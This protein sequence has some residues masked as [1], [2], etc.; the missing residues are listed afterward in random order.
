MQPRRSGHGGGAR[1]QPLYCA[2]CDPTTRARVSLRDRRDTRPHPHHLPCHPELRRPAVQGPAAVDGAHAGARSVRPGRQADAALRHVQAR[3]HRRLHAA[4]PTGS[5]TT[6]R[7]SS[8]G[9]SASVGTR[10]RSATATSTSTATQLDEPYIYATSRA[11]RPSR[12]PSPGDEDRWVDP[13]GELFLMGDHRSNSADSRDVRP[14]AGRQGHRPGV[15]AL[16]ADQRVRDPPDDRPTRSWHRR[17]N[18]RQP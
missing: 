7:R 15:A 14:G 3:R 1:G 11:S 10:S 17:P 16:L 9:S 5:R 2:P 4:A 12:R 18:E 6:T 8:S 13:D